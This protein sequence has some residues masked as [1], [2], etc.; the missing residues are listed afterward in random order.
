MSARRRNTLW[1]AI[2]VLEA[3]ETLNLIK[4]TTYAKLKD[5]DRRS[6]DSKLKSRAY[7]SYLYTSGEPAKDLKDSLLYKLRKVK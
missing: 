3:Q 1:L 5:N 2:D 6:F 4:A 7:P